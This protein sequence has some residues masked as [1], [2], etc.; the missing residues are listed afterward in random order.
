MSTDEFKYV[1]SSLN[2][3]S[4]HL[5]NSDKKCVESIC[6]AFSRLIDSF[7]NQPTIL[8]EIASNDLFANL[9]QL[10]V[11]TPPLISTNTFVMIIR[12]MSTACICSPSIAV[13][14]LKLNI[15]E[16]LC[17]LLIGSK[18]TDLSLRLNEQTQ[19][20][21]T[22]SEQST[23]EDEIELV[24]R[25]PQ[26]LYEIT[27]LIAELMPRLPTDGIFAVEALFNKQS[28]AQLD[29]VVWQWKDDTGNW[30]SYNQLD[31]RLLES[32]HLNQEEEISLNTM[33]RVYIIDFNTL[34]QIN[35][36][37][38]TSRAIQRKVISKEELN[39][40]STSTSA[41][42][43]DPRI[44]FFEN[45]TEASSK[46]IRSLFNIIYEIYNSSAGSSVRHKCLRALL[47]IIYYSSPD[48]LNTVLK[49]HAV[50]SHI[51]AML[52]SSDLRIVVGAIEMSNILMEKLSSI[53][54]VY[55]VREG[56][57][58]QFNKLMKECDNTITDFGSSPAF[59]NNQNSST[60]NNSLSNSPVGIKN[61]VISPNSNTN[62]KTSS[63]LLNNNQ[64]SP[65]TTPQQQITTNASMPLF[66]TQNI[67]PCY[68]LD[69]ILDATTAS[70]NCD[71]LV[72][73]SSAQ[74]SDQQQPNNNTLATTFTTNTTVA[75]SLP[76]NVPIN[77]Y[78][79]NGQGIVQQPPN[80]LPAGINSLASSN[81]IPP[82]NHSLLTNP[83]VIAYKATTD[84]PFNSLQQAANQ[85]QVRIVDALKRKR[86]S[87]KIGNSKAPGLTSSRKSKLDLRDSDTMSTTNYHNLRNST[88]QQSATKLSLRSS[89][90]C[91]PLAL[92]PLLN[93][94]LNTQLKTSPYVS[95]PFFTFTPSMSIQT[96]NSNSSN[97]HPQLITSTTISNH[98]ALNANQQA[99]SSHQLITTGNLQSAAVVTSPVYSNTS[100][101]QSTPTS[102]ART[103]GFKL[104]SAAAKTSS[105]FASLHPS[106][107]GKWS[108]NGQQSGTNSNGQSPL[109]DSSTPSNSRI[110]H[111]SS[112]ASILSNEFGGQ[113]GN[114]EKIKKWIKEQSRIFVEKYFSTD[115]E[116][117]DQENKQIA[118]NTLKKLKQAIEQLDNKQYLKSLNSIKN[119]LLEGDISSFELIHSGLIQKL[120]VF[121]TS[122]E[123]D[124]KNEVER[125]KRI[126]LFLHVFIKS[127]TDPNYISSSI[128]DEIDSQ[129]FSVL[130]A[131]LNACVSHLEQFPVRV[132]DIMPNSSG[133]IRGTS[134]LKFFHTHQLKCNLQRHKDCKNLKQ[135]RGGAVKIDPLAMVSAIERYL[136]VRGYGRIKE[137]TDDAGSDDDNSDEDFDDNMA[138]MI[139]QGQGRH[140]L[141]FLYGD[142][143]LPYNMTVYQAIRQFSS[144][145]SSSNGELEQDN[146]DLMSLW[147]QT[148]TI[149]YRP[150]PEQVQQTTSM[151]NSVV[152]NLTTTNT[153][154]TSTTINNTTANAATTTTSTTSSSKKYSKSSS[155]SSV[156][157]ILH[158][159]KDELWLE[160]KIPKTSNSI[161]ECLISRLPIQ[162]SIQDQ[163][164]EV[165][166]LLRILHG[167]NNYWGH[168][169]S[170]PNAYNAALSQSEFVNSK[171][172]AKA[173]R[174]L[175]D[176][177]MIM[178]GN[179]PLWLSQ[180]AYCCPFLFP[181]ECR[182]LLFY[183][184][185]F[186][187]DRALQRLLDSTQGLNNNDSNERVTPRIEKRKRIITRE[188]ILKQSE[189]LLNDVGN[190]KS[191]LEIRYENEVGTGKLAF[192]KG[193]L[194]NEILTKIKQ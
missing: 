7:H 190:S 94:N 161:L 137:S 50:S 153:T 110:Y 9:Q 75:A 182:H 132:H 175:Q 119:I 44:E 136:V 115:N 107:W 171:L 146:T 177:L 113:N 68:Q 162:D 46:F 49:C 85:T 28:F 27:S 165:I 13:D 86:N 31:S 191:L 97:N 59:V 12:M 48:L 72:N 21:S 139:S 35:E 29:E 23:K 130:I 181:F 53:F 38:G 156:N 26:K 118:T 149:V 56:V 14:L 142:H 89:N 40:S 17:Y 104:S 131:K 10:L 18:A 98:H 187:R 39:S 92:D 73:N 193:G 157:N 173:N 183:V 87:K 123:S 100:S 163:S 167:L 129:S 93:T 19:R 63:N 65:T 135:W 126:C 109:L 96:T 66:S 95:M 62:G 134:A 170:L 124:H 169:Y 43:V 143:I 52:A 186:D 176:P 125:E 24:T 83:G 116:D 30:Q 6:L 189:N 11:V 152:T 70:V 185:C 121:L 101:N 127:P 60:N 188:D 55:F 88:T 67:P 81:A 79:S 102:L 192:S 133:N 114:R 71:Q 82:T 47:R 112:N 147:N 8:N 32:S 91:D 15:Q 5:T 184:T 76:I 145:Y 22:S 194:F 45:E 1:Q 108:N 172:T 25:S 58:H 3:L 150:C 178:T 174:Q 78:W 36:E 74:P 144:S 105:F 4:A 151:G 16:T 180:L 34:Q 54:S 90:Q 138:A 42:Q 141:Q 179:F 77:Y 69:P 61:E 111:R 117:D 33:G 120:T 37:T 128:S 154:G 160:G 159:R 2:I 168:F 99:P 20:K 103:R 64:T 166:N 80:T 106:R 155:K 164:L 122:T 51:A 140:K 158:K 148:H 41:A 57:L 84:D